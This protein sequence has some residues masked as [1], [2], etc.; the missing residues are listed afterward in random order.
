MKLDEIFNHPTEIEWYEE[1]INIPVEA[2]KEEFKRL[3]KKL[4][5][6]NIYRKINEWFSAFQKKGN[7]IFKTKA[8]NDYF[9]LFHTS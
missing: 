6:W 9:D 2:D 3:I 8:I 1:K 5:L 4:E 7:N